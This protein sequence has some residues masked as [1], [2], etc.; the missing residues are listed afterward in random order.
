MALRNAFED[1]ALDSTLQ[2]T[3]TAI[4]DVETSVDAA[5]AAIVAVEA[6]V[7]SAA[8]DTTASIDLMSEQV[9]LLRKLLKLMESQATVD[10]LTRQ[11]VTVD[12]LTAGLTLGTVSSVTGVTTVTT[13]GTATTVNQFAGV[14]LRFQW[15]ENARIA[16]NTGIRSKLTY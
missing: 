5:T 8:T 1:L 3:N 14:D 2:D 9:I 4:A 11:R 6:A 10:G 15:M 7:D 12:A 16:Y 13:L